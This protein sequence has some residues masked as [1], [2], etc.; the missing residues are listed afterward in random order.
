MV[1]PSYISQNHRERTRRGRRRRRLKYTPL[2]LLLLLIM[3]TI[4]IVRTLIGS[5]T[6][7]IPTAD[8]VLSIPIDNI[9][10]PKDI[11]A[12]SSSLIINGWER[13]KSSHGGSVY[14]EKDDLTIGKSCIWQPSRFYYTNKLLSWIFFF[15]RASFFGQWVC[16]DCGE[17]KN[18]ESRRWE[19]CKVLNRRG[20]CPP[21]AFQGW[22]EPKP[23]SASTYDITSSMPYPVRLITSYGVGKVHKVEYEQPQCLSLTKPCFDI[24][25]CT[26]L[27]FNGTVNN[28]KLIQPL[29]VFAYPGQAH[30]DLEE[31]LNQSLSF[32]D[33]TDSTIPT[34]NI[35]IVEDPHMACLL[36]S[37]IDDIKQ[38]K[39]SP[40]WNLGINHY[41]YGVTKPIE[42]NIHFDMA[43]L[44]SAVLT[45]AQVRTGFDIPLP[46]PALWKISNLQNSRMLDL[47]R[48]RQFLLTFKGSIQDTQQPYYQHRWL[49]A[50]YLYDELDI[51]IDVQCKHKTLRGNT[52]VFASYDNPSQENFDN[53]MLNSTFSFS[54]GGSHVSSFR[55][56]EILS[57]GSIPVLLPEIVTPFFPELDWESCV[58]RVSQARI[59]DLPR[60]L[61]GIKPE[62]IRTRQ[63][64]CRRLYRDF[65]H[66]KKIKK[67]SF[68]TNY[69]K[70]S[71]ESTS[72]L[73]TT[74]LTVWQLR[75]E[76][77]NYS[78]RLRSRFFSSTNWN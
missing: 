2:F 20:K 33:K 69:K 3:P 39:V 9:K 35:R 34:N 30:Y 73:L 17:Q 49:A 54:P 78:N 36:I 11:I 7:V 32:P 55:F 66:Q 76:K 25:R 59:V 46:L 57:A 61:R 64:N 60:I 68:S 48:P 41:V 8:N 28:Q 65:L 37:H 13:L 56:T 15:S 58:I 18:L 42:E 27:S 31:A 50:E 24:D 43:A 53:F 77:Q 74:A 52:I 51:S 10:L 14:G 23:R 71:P 22:D 47:H 12:T 40:S 75:L 1:L 67:S 29:P 16:R 44:G 63:V 62:S 38:V 4:L 26:T 21:F 70:Q 5:M 19:D 6:I 72:K 45:N